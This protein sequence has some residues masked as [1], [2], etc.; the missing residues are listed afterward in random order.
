VTPPPDLYSQY[1]VL[2]VML[3]YHT[4]IDDA[5]RTLFCFKT[6]EGAESPTLHVNPGN[7]LNI[8]LMNVV[9]ALP[10]GAPSRAM[11]LESDLV[12]V[13]PERTSQFGAVARSFTGSVSAPSRKIQPVGQG[14]PHS[15]SA[16]LRCRVPLPTFNHRYYYVA[17]SKVPKRSGL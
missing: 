17:A 3:E 2:N 6:P 11:S 15:H 12:W 16:A 7:T 14:L 5:G 4:S 13:A 1:G 9:P 10:A 8:T